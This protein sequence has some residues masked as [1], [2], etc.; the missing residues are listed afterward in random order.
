VPVAIFGRKTARQRLRRATRE[1]LA[2]PAFSSPVDCTPWVIGGLWPAELSTVNAE[3]ATVAQYLKAD[4]QRIVKSANEELMRIRRAGMAE[5]AR[6]AEETR[7]I[8]AARAFAVRRVEST[9]RHLHATRQE[10]RTPAARRDAG[11]HGHLTARAPRFRVA[12]PAPPAVEPPPVEPPPLEPTTDV[13]E[14]QQY[15]ADGGLEATPGDEDHTASQPVSTG[16]HAAPV[17]EPEDIAPVRLDSPFRLDAVDPDVTEALEALPPESLEVDDREPQVNE[18]EAAAD[19]APQLQPQPPDVPAGVEPVNLT[20][21]TE[22]EPADTADGPAAEA[23]EPTAAD[24]T[25][26]A[27]ATSAPQTEAAE[28]T[29]VFEAQAAEP[30]DVFEAQAAEPADVFE[31]QAP[32]PTDVF[33]A[34]AP[35]ATDVFANA[36]PADTDVFEKVAAPQAP[37]SDG[38][39]AP[40]DA[41]TDRERLQR[42]LQFVARQE[43]GLRWAVGVRED[44]T[45]LVVTDL[46]YGWIP[47]G[48]TLPAGV[49]LLEPQR[50]TGNAAALLGHTIVSATY[51][52]GDSLGW[53]TDFGLTESSLQPREL[54]EVED[55]GWLLSEATHWRDGLPRMVHTLAKA[56]AAGTGVVEAELDVL[57]VHLDTARYQLLAQY[58]DVDLALLLNCLLLAATEG[59]ATGDRLSA[60][61]HFAWFQVLSAPPVSRF[62]GAP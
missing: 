42:L 52:P 58:P 27:D 12:P 38:E 60:N 51:A 48:L 15:I 43:P 6:Q 18:R 30:T 29:D 3:S 34:Q 11:R 56:G 22:P 23:A 46:A 7:V 32:E 28:P 33:E 8:H 49:R 41:E 31:A 54:P 4:L 45:T 19:A 35:E 16:K 61:Y 1:S 2:I 39:E 24:E 47:S 59:I 55:L 26:P 57:R 20:D 10:H 9:V 14:G 40:P 21:I 25:G 5:P 62:S 50:R 36:S 37:V 53:A 44:G 17:A 13:E